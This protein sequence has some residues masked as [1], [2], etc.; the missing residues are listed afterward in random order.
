MSIDAF[1]VEYL[2]RINGR[3]TEADFDDAPP[4]YECCG[5]RRV[6]LGCHREVI[7]CREHLWRLIEAIR[8]HGE[9]VS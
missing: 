7:P 9:V 8:H 4:F 1:R 6:A 2:R 3:I 5:E